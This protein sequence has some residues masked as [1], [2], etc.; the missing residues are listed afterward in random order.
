M[1]SGNTLEAASL[2]G[3]PWG[4]AV[5]GGLV[6]IG[7]AL[8]GI[9][10]FYLSRR[11]A[12]APYAKH[13][14]ANTRAKLPARVWAPAFVLYVLVPLL[15]LGFYGLCQY[16]GISFRIAGM[17]TNA[18]LTTG[19]IY[20]LLGVS[21]VLVFS[22]TRVLFVPQ[23]EFVSY[24]ALTMAALQSGVFP[25]TALLIV[26]V[27]A[28]CF[29]QETIRSLRSRVHIR[30]NEWIYRV[31]RDIV[32]PS[33]VCAVVWFAAAKETG[34]PIQAL[35]TLL[36]LIP[37]GPMVYRLAFEPVAHASTL[38]LLIIS[39]SVHFALMGLGLVMFGP[40]GVQTRPFIT[41]VV[42]IFGIAVQWQAIVVVVTAL[43]LVVGLYIYFEHSFM[44]KALKAMSVNR[45]GARLVGIN[46]ARAG[47]MTFVIA[48]A[49]GAVSG[50]LIS[51][52]IMVS[53][54]M[55][56]LMSLKGFVGS[57]FGGLASYPLTALGSI[58]VGLLESWSSFFASAYKEV[59]VFTL[60]I[61]LLLWLSLVSGDH[62]HEQED[63]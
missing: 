54:D 6:I 36:I 35:L 31:G 32:F 63:E 7:M 2:W 10:L 18:G 28:A 30:L 59:I 39:I 53:Y 48:A 1:A 52:L 41:G 38:T 47:R 34:L 60:I 42:R 40:E 5:L 50:I 4:Y 24:A 43:A 58:F 45:M 9:R 15:L 17:L 29:I 56:F 33:L 14:A 55:G 57:V 16:Q 22:V 21:I 19:V 26:V 27:G 62:A 11:P 49:L 13:L 3:F 20:A 61:P 51:P 12:D 46:T 8:F 44:G 25:A 37:L 23:G